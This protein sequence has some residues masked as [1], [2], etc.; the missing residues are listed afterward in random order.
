MWGNYYWALPSGQCRP[1]SPE[2]PW[3][4]WQLPPT[5][6]AAST[7]SRGQSSLSTTCMAHLQLCRSQLLPSHWITSYSYGLQ[8]ELNFSICS[9]QK[10]KALHYFVLLRNETELTGLLALM[11][12]ETMLTGQ[13]TW[14]ASS[15]A[16]SGKQLPNIS[17]LFSY[18]FFTI[19]QKTALQPHLKKKKKQEEK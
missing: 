3:Q 10:I 17:Y 19:K 12:L 13:K 7:Q 5:A 8:T 18:L 14:W 1:A 16:E 15:M 2:S 6:P 11:T 9:C 4:R